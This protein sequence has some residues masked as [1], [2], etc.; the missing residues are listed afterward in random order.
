MSGSGDSAAQSLLSKAKSLQ[1]ADPEEGGKLK[2]FDVE[3]DKT[4]SR[5]ASPST[6]RIDPRLICS[7]DNR[8]FPR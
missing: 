1:F 4:V 5:I 7:G 2:T 6:I 8:G 3:F